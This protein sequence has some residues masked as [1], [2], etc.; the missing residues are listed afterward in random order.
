MGMKM[1]K[2]DVCHKTIMTATILY[3]KNPLKKTS[4]GPVDIFPRNSVCSILGQGPSYFAQI[5]THS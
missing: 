5:N 2:H 3:G 4:P 1:Y